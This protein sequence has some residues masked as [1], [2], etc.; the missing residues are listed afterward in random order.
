MI[1]IS[2]RKLLTIQLKISNYQ[3][4]LTSGQVILPG[5]FFQKQNVFSSEII[6]IK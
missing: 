5:V 2:L 6:A 3:E 4:E 1:F